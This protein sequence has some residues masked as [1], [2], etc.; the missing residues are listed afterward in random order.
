M[1]ILT[2]DARPTRPTVVTIGSFDG[3]H[4]GHQALIARTL[5]LAR[6][7]GADPVVVTFD[8]HPLAVLRGN[9]TGYLITPG[10]LKLFYLEQFGVPLVKVLSFTKELAMVPPF[11]FLELEISQALNARA[12]VVGYNFTFGAGGA[13]TPETIRVFGQSRGI[14]VEVV[15][16]VSLT[17][18]A[19]ISSSRIRRLLQDGDLEGAQN[20][21]GHPF[22]VAGTVVAGEGRGRQIGVPTANVVP[23]S[24]QCMP[25]FGVYIGRLYHGAENWPAVANWGTRPTFSGREPVLEIHAVTGTVGSLYNEPVRFDLAA[26]VRE[27]RH[28]GAVDELVAQIHQDIAAARRFYGVQA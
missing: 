7:M 24:E 6:E 16:P 27:E 3:V 17:P 5:S 9:L 15:S 2:E 12:I 28:F 11:P 19:V 20:D 4:R 25:P 14:Q 26:R 22:S 21:L 10:P 1:Q 18:S 13:G 8:P 23:P